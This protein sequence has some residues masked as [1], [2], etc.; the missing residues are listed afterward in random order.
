MIP[1][2]AQAGVFVTIPI[3]RKNMKKFVSLLFVSLIFIPGVFSQTKT[4]TI[5]GKV[6]DAKS[7]NP[8]GGASVFC[9][10]TTVGT[11]STNDG[12]FG[13][14]MNNGGYDLVISYT[15]YETQVIRVSNSSKE[16]DSLV[17]LM[18]EQDK[19]MEAVAVTGSAE[20]ADGYTKYGAFFLENFIGSSAG[21]EKCTIS[22]PQALHFYFYKKR[23][24]LKVKAKDELII[25]NDNLGYRIKYQLD[26]F[27]YDYSTH[28][29]SYT[30]YPLFEQ[31]SG[32]PEQEETWTKNR[33]HAYIGSRL[34]FMRS[35]Y[36]STLRDEG[37]D[38]ESIDSATGKAA[39][40]SAPYDSSFYTMDSS[41]LNIDLHGKIRVT[42]R[43]QAPD[44]NYLIKNKF[45]ANA[46]LQISTIDMPN[47]ISIEEN[48]YFYF[49]D[50]TTNTGYW[51][52]K[53]LSELLPYDYNP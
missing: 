42:F 21:A 22:N 52:W 8:L 31:M 7:N 9:Q 1:D 46:R 20:V 30:G 18:K 43:N 29:S 53:K 49:Q 19:A 50:E 51:S 38:V 4:F 26:S 47:G 41:T 10:N 3:N 36:D 14:R 16:V 28:I 13:L 11:L 25:T 40:L 32:T 48:G 27:V 15:G 2:T 45:P 5:H 6:L 33:V 24:K 44:K 12:S 17:I 35:W 23:N 37:F 34:H 39:K